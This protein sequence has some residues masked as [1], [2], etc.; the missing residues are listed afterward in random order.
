MCEQ[1]SLEVRLT[2]LNLPAGPTESVI[3]ARYREIDPCR[4]PGLLR[5]AVED[6]LQRQRVALRAQFL[7]FAHAHNCGHSWA[8]RY[9][10]RGRG[11]G[12]VASRISSLAQ[13]E[14]TSNITGKLRYFLVAQPQTLAHRG[15]SVEKGF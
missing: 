5:N 11:S 14:L 13:S 7:V 12:T 3:T 1:G 2:Q 4:C 6:R 9:I 8:D 15:I 10:F